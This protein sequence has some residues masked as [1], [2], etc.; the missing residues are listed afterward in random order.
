MIFV[1][2]PAWILLAMNRTGDFTVSAS[3]ISSRAVDN[4]L[5][6]AARWSAVSGRRGDDNDHRMKIKAMSRP[7]GRSTIVT[8]IV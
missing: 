6:N 4:D 5:L 2:V 1:V 8:V 3:S 7:S